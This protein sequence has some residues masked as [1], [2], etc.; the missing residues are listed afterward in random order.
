MKNDRK[1]HDKFFVEDLNLEE[2]LNTPEI[3]KAY[4]DKPINQSFYK[5]GTLF[6]LCDKPKD[7]E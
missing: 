1:E 7:A 3:G 4:A 6:D 5:K 2:F